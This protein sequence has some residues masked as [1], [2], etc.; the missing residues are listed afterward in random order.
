MN[1]EEIIKA[2]RPLKDAPRVP[3]DRREAAYAR[4]QEAWQAGLA[5]APPAQA[6]AAEQVFLG[7]VRR[8][9]LFAVAASVVMGLA[10]GLGLWSTRG[11]APASIVA[12]VTAVQG[13]STLKVGDTLTADSRIVTGEATVALA[14]PSGLSVRLAP[15]SESVFES[16]ERLRL[17]RGRVYV[18]S[19]SGAAGDPW[20]V[21]TGLGEV[22]HL[23]TQYL[24][25]IGTD[26]LA[27]AVREGRI[28]LQPARG[29]TAQTTA[30][31]GERL[32]VAADAP[33]QILRTALSPTDAQWDWIESVPTSLEVEGLTLGEFLV[34]YRRE[35][36]Q[37]VTLDGVDAATR[38]HGSIAGLTPDEALEAI[39][40]ATDLDIRRV[41]GQTVVCA[42]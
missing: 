28:A 9:G 4:V 35:T 13:V 17:D 19:G 27:V 11:T 26:G 15:A 25:T 34:W 14:L 5:E 33:G 7:T 16:A 32:R 37:A 3:S 40:A 42:R 29:G 23:G 10:V 1:E 30:I 39:A 12:R 20:V 38:L 21:E 36:A 8:R 18:D 2:L 6:P 24:V 22:R 41:E 31:A